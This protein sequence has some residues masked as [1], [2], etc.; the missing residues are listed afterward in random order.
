MTLQSKHQCLGLALALLC[1]LDARAFV[2][3][4]GAPANP[5]GRK[6]QLAPLDSVATIA[7]SS[8]AGADT[9]SLVL[10]VAS[11]VSEGYTMPG[12]YVQISTGDQK[13][14]F[15]AI[16]SPPSGAGRLEFLVK[17]T[18]S[19]KWL[20]GAAKGATVEMSDVM[21][22]GFPVKEEFESYKY[23]F[24]TMNIILACTGSG[25]APIRAAIES[26]MLEVGESDVFGRSCTLYYGVRNSEFLPYKEKIAEWEGKGITV[27]PVLS[28]PEP[29]WTGRTGY[30]QAAIAEDNI[31][32]PRNTGC[33]LCGQKEMVNE[34]KEVLTAAGVFEGRLLTN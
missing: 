8:Q 10:E 28:Q 30:V 17:E 23:D 31:R 24:P 14:G 4:P 7:E 13:P 1:C 12:Q 27:V 15:Y 9:R 25:I 34:T 33:L 29:G 6:G 20:T 22:K 3:S 18:D 11:E 32:I 19:N 5:V 2:S 21:G 26:S 16:A